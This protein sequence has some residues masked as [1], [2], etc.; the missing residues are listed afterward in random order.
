MPYRPQYLTEN[1]DNIP[2]DEL[3]VIQKYY[4][5]LSQITKNKESLRQSHSID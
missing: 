4:S 1:S 3:K 5:H 2:E